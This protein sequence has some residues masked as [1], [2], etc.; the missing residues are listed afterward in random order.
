MGVIPRGGKV[1]DRQTILLLLYAHIAEDQTLFSM[2]R[3]NRIFTTLQV[4]SMWGR[5]R[6]GGQGLGLDPSQ[7]VPENV[8]LGLGVDNTYLW[9]AI[10]S[11]KIIPE[12]QKTIK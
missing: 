4:L 3:D 6:N 9:Q 11:A 10:I 12:T 7:L 2:Q 8:H 5:N 1:C